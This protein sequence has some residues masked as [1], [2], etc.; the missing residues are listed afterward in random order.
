MCGQNYCT[1]F[2]HLFNGTPESEGPNSVLLWIL[3]TF[4]A[5]VFPLDFIITSISN[6]FLVKLNGIIHGGGHGCGHGC[7]MQGSMF[8]FHEQAIPDVGN[9]W[10]QPNSSKKIRSVWFGMPGFANQFTFQSRLKNI[11]GDYFVTNDLWLCNITI[12]ENILIRLPN[13][14]TKTKIMIYFKFDF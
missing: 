14:D 4:S 1:R 13:N 2:I 5:R 6:S 7:I 11:D 12:Y 8:P 10:W 9:L 3:S